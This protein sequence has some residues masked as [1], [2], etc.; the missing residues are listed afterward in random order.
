LRN[1]SWFWIISVIV[2][3]A[4]LPA[5]L[6]FYQVHILDLIMLFI[7]LAVGLDLTLGYCGQVNLGHAAFYAVGAYTTAILTT[8]FHFGFWAALPIS[9]LLSVLCGV[10]IGLPSLKVRSHYL[11]IATIG[12]SI[13]LND[14]LINDT[15]LTG[16]P[17]G[18]SRIPKPEFFGIP[19]NTEYRYYYLVLTFAVLL[20]LLARF[21]VKY[22]L[23]R[24]FR[25]V[26]E[27]HI[28]AQALGINI[29]AK[30]I[31]AFGFSGFY[32]GIAGA[33]YASM[34]SY[35]SPDSFQ[36]NEMLFI[37]TTVVIG[38][39]GNIYGAVSGATLLI[40]LRE[41][42]NEFQNWQQVIYGVLI[43]VLVVFLPGGLISITR[44]GKKKMQPDD[45]D[46]DTSGSR[47]VGKVLANDG[48]S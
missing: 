25:A 27:D 8:H 3:A 26:R 32:A 10:F 9:V 5:F 23:G 20:F 28:A 39:M 1:K 35:V 17:T 47:H 44:M 42:L 38:G 4:I 7:I 48:N 41:L 13:A 22:G 45:Y 15:K 36:F 21:I 16:G 24:S 11:A 43:V 40:V 46:Q 29:A 37:L 19:L 12:L 33:L 2:I 6:G 14:I 31:V 34:L 30:Q 18:I